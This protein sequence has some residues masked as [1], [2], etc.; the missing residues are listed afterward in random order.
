MALQEE[1]KVIIE[2]GKK[3]HGSVTPVAN[4]NSIL[5][6][7][8][9]A[10]LTDKTVT[11]HNVPE[12]S[13]VEKLLKIMK[14]LGAKVKRSGDEVSINCAKVSTH[15]VDQNIGSTIRVSLLLAGPL[16][17]RFGKASIPLPGGCALGN[18]GTHA[19][20]DVFTQA[21][22][23]IKKTKTT[24]EF[25]APKKVNKVYDIYPLE[26]SVTA[27]EN[28]LMY[29]AGSTAK[30]ILN[31]AATEPHVV[32]L[33]LMLERMGVSISGIRSNF[34]TVQGS[35]YP[36]E[37]TDFTPRPDFV[38]IAGYIVAA[39]ITK[40]EI[41]ILGANIPDIVNPMI[42]WFKMFNITIKTKGEDLIVKGNKKLHI[43]E[44]SG[45][46]EAA[47]GLAKLYPRPWPGF[48]VDVI[49]VV[50]TLAC[51]SEG[52]LVLQNWMYEDGLQFVREL[53]A[54]GADIFS[55]SPQR[56]I[57]NGPT[58]FQGGRVTPPRVIQSAKAIFLAALADDTTTTLVGIDTLER[59]FPNLI[60][61][62]K[63]LGASIK[64]VD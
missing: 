40:G 12:T 11:Y 30:I 9:A 54:L 18:R 36:L 44:D 6:A 49:P 22:V 13:D 33:S 28:I 53:S 38:D 16:L 2:G 45:F 25:I 51:K 32:D 41:T 47:P 34:I 1:T 46:P 5:A 42:G 24:L 29:A 56:L 50:A 43:I 52:R 27:T 8:P 4:K 37:G 3:L 60:E 19:H 31:D 26:T 23:E 39:A 57:I 64:I 21:G 62:Y 15:I 55:S 7:I 17:A 14:L 35:E 63:K 20:E 61:T 59:R 10:I 58:K 48:P